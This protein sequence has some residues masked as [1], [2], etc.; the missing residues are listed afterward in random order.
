MKTLS[1]A[2]MASM[3]SYATR[4]DLDEAVRRATPG[5]GA[6]RASLDET[7]PGRV[8]RPIDAALQHVI[9]VADKPPRRIS[10]SRGAAPYDWNAC[11]WTEREGR[12][13]VLSFRG[14]RTFGDVV[15]DTRVCLVPCLTLVR[16]RPGPGASALRAPEALRRLVAGSVH[17][18]FAARFGLFEG[19]TRDLLSVKRPRRLFMCAHSLG[20]AVAVVAAVRLRQLTQDLGCEVHVV[21][22]GCPKVGSRA[23]LRAFRE[24]VTSA[25]IVES[26]GDPIPHLP[27]NPMYARMSA[28]R[29]STAAAGREL[30]G[31]S[32][33]DRARRRASSVA[34]VRVRAA[35]C[36][37]PTTFF[38]AF[39]V[40]V[41]R[42]LRS[43]VASHACAWYAA[44]V[45]TWGT[46]AVASDAEVL[47]GREP[48][49]VPV[50]QRSEASR[51]SSVAWTERQWLEQSSAYAEHACAASDV[52]EPVPRDQ[53]R[54]DDAAPASR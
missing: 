5:V 9:A 39:T 28:A 8:W 31:G 2:C 32:V 4:A 20:A 45:G 43:M 50:P 53:G 47:P 40:R 12:D 24:S 27:L 26:A 18:G 42:P 33:G 38:C 15:S 34:V 49:V 14:T 11:Y 29:A 36:W 41:P 1:E 44:R 13:L 21:T 16:T 23:F 51:G 30:L 17:A 22:F 10:T 25:T 6:R 52:L 37:A 7:R 35:R 54:T 46:E 48:A 19:C 3:T